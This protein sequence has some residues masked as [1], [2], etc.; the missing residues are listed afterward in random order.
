MNILTIILFPYQAYPK[1]KFDYG[2]SDFKTGDN[3]NQWEVRD[4][5]VV[6]GKSD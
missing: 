2:V 4:G 5:D 1:Y 3:K 6:K